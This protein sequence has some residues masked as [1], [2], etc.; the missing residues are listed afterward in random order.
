M[1]L[2]QI[3]LRT[4]Y[5]SIKHASWSI[6]NQREKLLDWCP[7]LHQTCQLTLWNVSAKTTTLSI[8]HTCPVESCYVAAAATYMPA[9]LVFLSQPPLLFKHA[10]WLR[11]AARWVLD[12]LWPL[13]QHACWPKLLSFNIA[14]E[15]A[16]CFSICYTCW[17][18]V[19]LSAVSAGMVSHY[20]PCL[21]VWLIIKDHAFW[22][23]T[24]LSAMPVGVVPHF[25]SCLLV[26]CLTVGHVFRCG[27]SL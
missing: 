4:W 25:R 19:S 23:G 5:D 16:L 9:G 27:A 26:W 21:L 24:S 10:H 14:C 15:L 8:Q 12:G 1:K 22:F 18:G 2:Q 13:N 6:G 11:T 17:Y 3:C 7:P 20:Q